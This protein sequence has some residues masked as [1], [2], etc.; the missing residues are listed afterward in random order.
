M[1]RPASL[2]LL[3]LVL[4][5]LAL[6][7]AGCQTPRKTGSAAPALSDD[8]HSATNRPPPV[9]RFTNEVTKVIKTHKWN[10]AW[11]FGNVDDP[12]PTPD[13]RPEDPHRVRKWYWRNACH[14]FTF[15]VIGIAD[16]SFVR[17]GRHANGVFNPAGGWNFAACKRGWCRLPFVSYQGRR[18]RWYFGW[19]ER[20]NFG[21][22]LNFHGPEP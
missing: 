21:V 3:A 20:G 17:T 13:Y 2:A 18:C 16:K 8:T 22:K 4:P 6:L 19:R 15:Y 9:T 7:T 14:N 5:V 11:W 12:V 10:P 1:N